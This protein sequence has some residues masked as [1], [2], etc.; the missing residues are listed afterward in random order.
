MSIALKLCLLKIQGASSFPF[1]K[2]LHTT[3]TY[4]CTCSA[5]LNQIRFFPPSISFSILTARHFLE[6]PK[7]GV[8]CWV[9]LINR[10]ISCPSFSML[11]KGKKE[12]DGSLPLLKE[13][14]VTNPTKQHFPFF[15]SF[16]LY[17]LLG[18]QDNTRS[19]K[20]FKFGLYGCLILVRM[21]VLTIMD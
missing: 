7:Q 10:W 12:V 15:F 3:C 18:L 9:C 11:I 14:S 8:K 13:I 6:M 16:L 1:L 5:G 19:S 17:I 21:P 4:Q 2:F 20:E